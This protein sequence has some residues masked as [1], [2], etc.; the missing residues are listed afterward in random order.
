MHSDQFMLDFAGYENS[1]ALSRY[2]DKRNIANRI[3]NNLDRRACR[4]ACNLDHY[5]FSKS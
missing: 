4:H 5:F 3:I 2:R 1:N